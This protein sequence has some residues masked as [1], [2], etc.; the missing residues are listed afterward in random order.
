[1]D[2]RT[3]AKAFR[4]QKPMEDIDPAWKQF[5]NGMGLPPV[6]F[7]LP[8]PQA[9]VFTYLI[10]NKCPTLYADEHFV[11]FLNSGLPYPE[12]DPRAGM[13]LVHLMACPRERIYSARTLEPGD[14]KLLEHMRRTMTSLMDDRDFREKALRALDAK[15]A[16]VDHPAY[17]HDKNIFLDHVDDT[18]MSYWFHDDPSVGHLH[19]HCI[20]DTLRTSRVHDKRNVPYEEV[21]KRCA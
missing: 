2:L 15:M 9:P 6:G 11:V 18:K 5:M 21:V 7:D 1:M 13:S 17:T 16:G 3:C 14:D 10:D 20:Q 4:A 12:L 19:M 8:H